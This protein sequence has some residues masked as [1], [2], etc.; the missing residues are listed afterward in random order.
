MRM[1]FTLARNAFP[2][3]KFFGEDVEIFCSNFEDPSK[4]QF[5]SRRF[6]EIAAALFRRSTAR[7]LHPQA[8]E[9]HVNHLPPKRSWAPT[10]R[11]SAVVKVSEEDAHLD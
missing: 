1:E 4:L 7:Y 6:Q 3:P 2:F 9:A 5:P 11:F 10:S 8:R